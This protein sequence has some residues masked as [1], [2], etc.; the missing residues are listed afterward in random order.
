MSTRFR[1]DDYVIFLNKP[2][3][4]YIVEKITIDHYGVKYSLQLEN[5]IIEASEKEI[6]LAY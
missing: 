6:E 4:I 3:Q 1:I 5:N 2:E